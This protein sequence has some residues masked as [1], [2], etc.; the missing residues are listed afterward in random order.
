VVRKCMLNLARTRIDDIIT[1]L[2]DVFHRIDFARILRPEN[3]SS[4]QR[5]IRAMSDCLGKCVL[6]TFSVLLFF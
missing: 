1:N 2:I 5:V 4:A 3:L 6:G